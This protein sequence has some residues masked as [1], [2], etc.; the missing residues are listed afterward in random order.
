MKVSTKVIIGALVIV[1]LMV[2][3][4]VAISWAPDKTVA[5]L[6]PRW[7]LPPS[8]FVDIAGMRVHVRDQGPAEDPVPI[9]LIHGTS[10]SLHTWEGWVN[11]LR[12]RHRVISFDL[13]GF[14]LTGPSPSG[15]Y[16]ADANVRFMRA[17]LDALQIQH[18]VLAGNSL[19]GYI[20]L[21]A[22]FAMPERVE[23][24]ILVDSGGY[25]S[26]ATSMPIGFRIARM[27]LLKHLMQSM[28][29]RSM[30]ESSL[31]SVYGDPDRVTA[32]L[33]DRYFDLTL[34]QGNRAA[35]I[36]RFEQTDFGGGAG[37]I[38]ELKLPVL[39]IWGGRDR[40]I[41]PQ[42]A[43]RFHHDIV[44][45]QLVIFEDLG[46]VPQEEDPVRTVA[47]VSRFLGD[48]NPH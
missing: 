7:A 47:A 40:L 4:A 42:N 26:V 28:L 19:G 38:A 9:I 29:P 12:G 15:D 33:V 35:L 13:P 6:A 18:C 27:P 25:P 44:G 32:A 22:T 8:K 43:E 45:S 2:G 1:V 46:H 3:A 14:G 34:R 20:A 41:P 39:I 5:Q 31:H 11:A 17:L 10:A 48:S 37:K 21:Q 30:I 16:S 36:Q 24:L 23:K